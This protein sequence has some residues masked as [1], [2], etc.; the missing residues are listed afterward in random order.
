MPVKCGVSQGS[1]FGPLIFIL[2]INDLPKYV[3]SCNLYADDTMIEKSGRTLDEIIPYIQSDID[4]LLDSQ[5]AIMI[6][7]SSQRLK[8][9][10]NCQHI[11]LTIASSPLNYSNSY[12]YLG[13]EIDSTFSWNPVIKNVCKKLR[14]SL[15][16]LQQLSH[17]IP[18]RSLLTVYYSYFQCHID[19]C[20][21]IWGHTMYTKENI[22][23]IQGFQNKPAGIIS[24]DF[25]YD[26]SGITAVKQL[27]FLTVIE[28]R[29]YL[30]L[31]TVFKCLNGLAP[32]Y[33][34][35]SFEYVSDVHSRVTRQ[36]YHCLYAEITTI[37]RFSLVELTAS[38]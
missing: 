25:D 34:S 20:L 28:R 14:S 2:F 29:G 35:D 27:G 13:I 22:H 33:L 17:T 19:Y 11:G 18:P 21:S 10:E 23:K 36:C 31:I 24:N 15:S 30:I 12:N 3:Q 7:G 1:I 16:A 5:S 6:I 37:Q 9:F 38:T 8:E 32:H 26:H 4:N